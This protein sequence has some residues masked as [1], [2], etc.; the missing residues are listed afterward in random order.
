MA[1]I[2][3]DQEIL[4]DLG[5]GLVLRRSTRA[6]AAELADFNA[7]VHSELGPDQPNERVAAWT[8]DLMERPHPTFAPCDFA[9]VVDTHTGRIVSATNL[10][11]QTW[12]YGGVPFGV[13]RPELVGTW[14]EYRRRGLIRA[15]VEVIHRWSAERGKLV[16]AISGIRFYYR[17]FGYEM[18]LPLRG[19]RSGFEPNMPQ[20]KP[21]QTEPYR[22]RPATVDDLPFLSEVYAWAARRVLV[23]CRLDAAQWRYELVGRSVENEDRRLYL[24]IETPAGERIGYLAHRPWLGTNGGVLLTAYELKPNISW[25]AVSP[26]ALRYLWAV[27]NEY[28]ARDKGQMRSVVLLLGGEHPAYEACRDRLPHGWPPYA[29]YLRVPDLPGFMRCIAP[30]LERRLA[31]PIAAGHTGELKLSFYRS[32]LRI[33]MDSGRLAT[34]EAWEPSDTEDGDAGFPNLTFLQLLF[35]YRALD[36][37]KQAFPDCWCGGDDARVL[38]ST[39]FPRQAS[40]VWGVS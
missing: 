3:T 28:A 15:Q 32:G 13:G 21:D 24:I 2:A 17:Q 11:S 23:A 10:I 35:G 30:V 22:L 5:D 1:H 16:Q 37:L 25:L 9:L 34:I 20:L 19:G 12:T 38:L 36:E 27:G 40:D 39:L 33:V 8:H 18:A 6:D 29:W 7:R 26:S 31:G 4:R 14:P